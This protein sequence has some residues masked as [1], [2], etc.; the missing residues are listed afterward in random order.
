M[1]L[2]QHLSWLQAKQVEVLAAIAAHTDT[3][4][5]VILAAGGRLDDVFAADWDTAVEEVA[6]A[7]RLANRTAARRLEAATL[8]ADRHEIT[9]GLLGAGQ[10]SCIQAQTLAEQLRVVDDSVAAQV[11]QVMAV[12]MPGQAAGQTRAAL[13]QEVQRAD[14]DGAERRHR[15]RVRE[16]RMLRHPDD[17]GMALFGAVLP[18][19]QAALMEQAVDRRAQGYADDGRGLEQKRGDALFDLVVNQPG[20]VGDWGTGPLPPRRLERSPSRRLAAVAHRS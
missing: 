3:P 17:D 8:L 10:I 14:P 19:Q 4:E 2:E 6:C 15:Q 7:L 16:R 20:A 11:E 1:V 9:T 12:K 5:E 18:A 13:R